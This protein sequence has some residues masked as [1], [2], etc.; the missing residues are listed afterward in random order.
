MTGYYLGLYHDFTCL[1]SAC[2]M[3]CC[4]GW[5]IVVD[6]V[7]RQRYSELEDPV[8]REDIMRHLEEKDGE[9]VF[10]HQKEG[11][12]AML[13]PDGLCRIQRHLE[14][15][16]LCIT[17]RKFP[18]LAAQ[19]GEKIWM[20]MAASCPAVASYLW[21]EPLQWIVQGE[22][23]RSGTQ[24]VCDLEPV[25]TAVQQYEEDKQLLDG[26]R[27]QALQQPQPYD[28]L[29]M[30]RRRCERY[31]YCMDLA[32]GVSELLL[33]F[34]DRKYLPGS[35][36]FYER[37]DLGA[38]QIAD[39]IERFD[40]AYGGQMEA[41]AARYVPYRAFSRYL[42][43]PKERKTARIRQ[44][45]G[46]MAVFYMMCLSRYAA[47]GEIR[48]E[49]ILETLCWVYR[50]CANGARLADQ[51]QLFFTQVFSEEKEFVSVWHN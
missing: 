38:A 4:S 14:E 27:K 33:H 50:F 46:E 2:P 13:D 40:T 32:E 1:A 10:S 11:Q 28:R 12:C 9:I 21:R 36:E 16:A 51:V 31:G 3:T 44:I 47:A 5:K 48:E 20:S 8:L 17:C 22:K 35:M 43:Y 34:P 42:E 45:Y 15:H 37:M 18:R 23:S 25:H 30:Y 24:T 19:I 39:T 6:P 49:Q 26:Q 7:S 41:F 29:W